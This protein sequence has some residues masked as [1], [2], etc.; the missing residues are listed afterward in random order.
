M[1]EDDTLLIAH[2]CEH[3]P[4]EQAGILKNDKLLAID[5]QQFADHE[6][7]LAFMGQR[8]PLELVQVTVM[9]QDEPISMA[10]ELGGLL[11]R[12]VVYGVDVDGILGGI[13]RIS[14]V[15]NPRTHLLA[16]GIGVTWAIEAQQ[17]LR[18]D[19]GVQA[20]VWSVT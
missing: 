16:S 15:E 12:D 4:A 10:V 17:L 6:E 19:W 9:R 2:V 3:G 1:F 8:T 5:Q 20:D 14:P 18:D 13:H 7:F 11:S